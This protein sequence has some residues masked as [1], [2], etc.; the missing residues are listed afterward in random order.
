MG[1]GT[2]PVGRG[3]GDWDSSAWIGIEGSGLTVSLDT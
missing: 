3:F 2:A 1:I